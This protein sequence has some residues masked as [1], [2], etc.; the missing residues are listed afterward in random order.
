MN[1]ING[2]NQLT[3]SLGSGSPSPVGVGTYGSGF[4][5]CSRRLDASEMRY[6]SYSS[7]ADG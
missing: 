5:S 4:S 6:S 3:T 7:W 2:Y 1:P